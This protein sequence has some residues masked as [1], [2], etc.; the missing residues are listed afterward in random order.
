GAGPRRGVPCASWLIG[1]DGS[2][3]GALLKAWPC[4][5]KKGN[6]I[7]FLGELRVARPMFSECVDLAVK[8]CCYVGDQFLCRSRRGGRIGREDNA[9][10]DPQGRVD[11]SPRLMRPVSVVTSI[12]VSAMAFSM[13]WT[14]RSSYS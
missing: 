9:C 2:G 12:V 13:A 10:D 6:D 3:R 11:T 8:T 7:H 14:R 5:H 4:I 1:C